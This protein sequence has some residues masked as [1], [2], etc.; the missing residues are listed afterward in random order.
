MIKIAKR[1]VF[2]VRSGQK[3]LVD[4]EPLEHQ[5][6]AVA[7]I[8][9]RAKAFFSGRWRGLNLTCRWHTLLVGGTGVGKSTLANLV[10]Q[11][12]S[13]VPIRV[14]T[15]GYMPSG[16]HNRGVRETIM[17]I[18]EHVASNPRTLLILDEL[19]KLSGGIGGG[20]GAGG[21]VG[22]GNVADTWQTYIRGEL[23]ELTDGRWPAGLNLMNLDVPDIITLDKL[24]EKLRETVF[25]LGIGTFQGVLDSTSWRTIGFSGSS[26]NPEGTQAISNDTVVEYLGRELGNRFHSSIV[27]LPELG[28]GDYHRIAAEAEL[29]LPEDLREPFR[30]EVVSRIPDAITNKKS[31]RFLEEALSAVLIHMPDTKEAPTVE[32]SPDDL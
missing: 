18:A 29:K 15:Q 12:C 32:L 3:I 30:R 7:E 22:G 13:A 25:I 14:A 19:E 4:M 9:A 17:I 24:T 10:A 21:V 2:P 16:A 28:A 20:R 6:E 31:V 27:R 11:A 26:A 23:Q 5:R 8:T 1:T